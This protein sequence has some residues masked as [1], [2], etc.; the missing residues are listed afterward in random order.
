MMPISGIGAFGTWEAAFTLGASNL[1]L[2]VDQAILAGFTT[3][4][5]TQLHDYTLGVLALLLLMR[6][7][8]RRAGSLRGKRP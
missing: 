6:P 5:V 7:A 3:H 8:I 1:G 4:A 2:T